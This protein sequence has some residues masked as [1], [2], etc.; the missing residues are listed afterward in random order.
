MSMTGNQ[1]SVVS[2]LPVL[3]IPDYIDTEASFD[4]ISDVYSERILRYYRYPGFGG[5]TLG[6]PGL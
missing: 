6:R 4:V 2:L 5:P 1:D 3:V